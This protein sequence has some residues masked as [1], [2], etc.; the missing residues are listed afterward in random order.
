M[1][2]FKPTIITKKGHA[3][4]AKIVAGKATPKFTKISVSD[5]EYSSSTNF[6]SVTNL[7]SIKQ[8]T[9]VSSVSKINSAAVKVSGALSNAELST[10]YYLRTIGLYATDPT[11]GEILY[12]ITTATKPDW[13]PPNNGVSA[14]SIMIDLITVVSNASNVS[15]DVDPNATATVAQI[16]ELKDEMDKNKTVPF[17]T[18][19]KSVTSYQGGTKG[20]FYPEV[21]GV[22]PIYQSMENGNFSDGINGWNASFSTLAL[23]GKVLSVSGNGTSNR[24]RTYKLMPFKSNSKYFIYVRVRMLDD[25][26]TSLQ[27]YT[28]G[29]ETLHLPSIVNPEKDKWYELNG[30]VT[31]GTGTTSGNFLMM[32]NYDDAQAANGKTMQVDGNTGLVVINM[33]QNGIQDY[34][35]EQMLKIVRRGYWEGLKTPVLSFDLVSRGKN[36]CP[37]FEK[38]KIDNA[39]LNGNQV[40]LNQTTSKI[41]SPFI[42]LN[43]KFQAYAIFTPN[44]RYMAN[45]VYY[46]S[47]FKKIG[48]NGEA[49]LT[50]GNVQKFLYSMGTKAM[51]VNAKYIKIIIQRD[52]NYATKN[53]SI[54]DLVIVIDN[55]TP[56]K[57]IK[58]NS[59]KT[60]FSVPRPLIKIDNVK[61]EILDNGDLVYRN[62]GKIVLDGSQNVRYAS[63]TPDGHQVEI[64]VNNA[65]PSAGTGV[66]TAILNNYSYKWGTISNNVGRNFNMY[67]GDLWLNLVSDDT[68]WSDTHIPSTS[69]LKLYFKSLFDSGNPLIV[70]YQLAEPEI[71]HHGEQGYQAPSPLPAYQNG[72]L[73]VIPKHHKKYLIKNGVTITL[74]EEI[75][76]LDYARTEINGKVVDL[77]C[78]LESDGK[79]VTIPETTGWVDIKGTVPSKNCLNPEICADM[80]A[81][82]GTITSANTT[83]IANLQ[84]KYD[85]HE[86]IQDL[87][88]LEMDY[89]LTILENK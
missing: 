88:N 70:Y 5:H 67:V 66:Q 3:L 57:Y 54:K 1:A 35:E 53:Y 36:I 9:L 6:E 28:S 64:S 49:Q 43:K 7:S 87:I 72:D 48:C 42:A 40:E 45:C 60:G 29:A 34:T 86:N 78:T 83:S 44:I 26:A 20:L 10:G 4:M 32:F 17:S 58:Y 41:T 47:D 16:N 50:S 81:N 76:D 2:S 8:T 55:T 23:N 27:G 39:T 65:L 80:P 52:P 37:S 69:E 62:S 85:K 15:I 19:G 18:E 33:T 77:D 56:I 21:K 79:T 75:C 51:E 22:K 68:P 12:S 24:I 14:S 30:I 71:I 31:T 11:E 61:D 74:D 73:L 13:I 82:L 38:W 46:S 89:R 63:K 84:Q 25:N 59:T